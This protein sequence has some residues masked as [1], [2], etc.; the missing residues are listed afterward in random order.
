[1]VPKQTRDEYKLQDLTPTLTPSARLFKIALSISVFLH[2]LVL[3]V[4][5]QREHSA[6]HEITT[7]KNTFHISLS[8]SPPMSLMRFRRWKKL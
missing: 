3:F 1:M 6:T 5:I 8:S 4:V 7:V 2:G